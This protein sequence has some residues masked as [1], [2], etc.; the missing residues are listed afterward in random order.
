MTV[1]VY[2]CFYASTW[3]MCHSLAEDLLLEE[4][5]VWMRMSKMFDENRP[6]P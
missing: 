1:T 2:N 6:F 5:A 4:R 3:L